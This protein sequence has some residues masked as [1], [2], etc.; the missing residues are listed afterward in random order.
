MAKL[1]FLNGGGGRFELPARGPPDFAP[2]ITSFY[3]GHLQG[4]LNI[5]FFPKPSLAQE[6]FRKVLR[7]HHGGSGGGST[8][9]IAT[10]MVMSTM[11]VMVTT[12]P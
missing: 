11:M 5:L 6:S 10:A 3:F 2:H 7:W 9:T 12:M 4:L 8:M 1:L